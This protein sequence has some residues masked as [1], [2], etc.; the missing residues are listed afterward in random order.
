M[1]HHAFVLATALA[2]FATAH[3]NA[4]ACDG[5][6]VRSVKLRTTK[7]GLVK[8][9]LAITVVRPG[10]TP[11]DL[12]A[13][14]DLGL[15]L[16]DA[17]DELGA[18]IWETTVP[19]D[20][21]VPKGRALRSDTVV[22]RP[23]RDQADAVVVKVRIDDADISGLAARGG[24]RAELDTGARC[25]RSCVIACRAKGR[26]AALGCKA[27]HT[28]VGADGAYGAFRKARGRF[29]RMA[30]S[31]CPLA[32]DLRDGCD[33]L[34]EEKCILPF[35]TDTFLADDPST[36]TGKR[37]AYPAES[38][39][40]NVS[41]TYIDPTDWNTL[42]GFSPGPMLVALFPDTGA[43]VD[44]S[45]TNVAFHT[46]FARSLD[47][48]HPIVLLDT[49]SGERV[50]H[51]AEMDANTGDVTKRAL[52]IRPARRLENARRYVV[53]IRNLVDTNGTPIRPRLVFRALR[54]A[55]PISAD[56]CGSPCGAFAARFEDRYER[57][58]DDLAAAG[59]ARDDLILAWDF[60]TASDEALTGWMVSVRDQAFA[61]P[62]P[63]FTVTSVNEGTGSGFNANVFRRI[64][65]T[66]QAPLF[67]TADAP[68]SRLNLVDGVPTQNG[69]ATVPFVVDIPHSAVPPDTGSYTPSRASLWGH[70]LLGTRYQLGGLS[71]FANGNAI[72]M[73]AVDM[74]GMA[75]EDVGTA[76][77]PLI[78]DGSK[79]HFIPERLHQ[80][81]LNHLLLG[82]LLADGVDGFNSDPAF[83][84]HA[85]A[86]PAI[87]TS[88]V[89]YSGGSQGGI[90]GLTIM[91]VATNFERGFL[92]VPGANYSTLL[93]RAAPFK[94][95]LDLMR[96][97]YPDRL[98]ETLIIALIQQ[99]W[100]RADPNSYLPHIIPS[101]LSDPPVPHRVLLHMSTCDSQVSNLGTEIAVRSLGIPQMAPPLRSF[102]DVPE[103]TVTVDGSALQEIDWQRCDVSR[104]NTPA[105]FDDGD[106]CLSDA[107]CP[108]PN[109]VMSGDVNR[110][111][112]DS[113][114]PPLENLIPRF[115]NGAHGAEGDAPPDSPVTRQA[116]G[117]LQPNG[118]I[119]PL[120]DGPCDPF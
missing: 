62:T 81:I 108:G 5:A 27:S 51:F 30:T 61:L 93:R 94:L 10:V 82:R 39:P 77:V 67:M 65:G 92:A 44:P 36:P 43:P 13:D 34:V 23:A 15:R 18:A 86:R 66:F 59:V 90:F 63:E 69:F 54:D 100:D 56:V 80:G 53:A 45:A 74:Q 2:L 11:A 104:C 95:Y 116:D 47:A 52:I 33:P 32:L 89:Y 20:A 114:R 111:V 25:A 75:E 16:L 118:V 12:V 35:P 14:G 55:D 88:R 3:A 48:D 98:D 4:A 85:D 24:L 19:A 21:F 38:L 6:W 1:H 117:F 64:E 26:R 110:T 79:F 50:P 103:S 119:E 84:F 7:S 76:V 17:G 106:V 113:G 83:Q 105:G 102:F 91:G 57:I 97:A 58:F 96:P 29:A 120:C 37:L 115:D 87:D 78:L 40:K 31:L 72:V 41:G 71:S 28:F 101:D 8:G 60:T 68:A 112:C 46:D 73:A 109:D 42:D 107:D 99:L 70:G 22:L 49:V 9:R